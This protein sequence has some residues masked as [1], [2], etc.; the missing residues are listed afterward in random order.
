MLPV[1][2][3]VT[4][5]TFLM[6]HLIP[7]DPA[8]IMAGEKARPDAVEAMRV[9]LGLDKP[10][11]ERYW[12]YLK[13]LVTLD[14]GTSMKFSRPV[15]EMIGERLPV[16]VVLTLFSTALGLLFALPL[17]YISGTHK[18]QPS[19]H[20]IRISTLVAIAMPSFWIGLLLMIP[21]GKAALVACGRLGRDEHFHEA[22]MP[23]SAG[24]YAVA[25]DGCNPDQGHAKFRGGYCSPGLRGF[26]QVQGPFRRRCAASPYYSKFNGVNRNPAVHAHGRAAGRQCDYRNGI[27]PA[28]R[29]ADL[30]CDFRERLILWYSR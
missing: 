26:R 30:R 18:D 6:I 29:Q 25:D 5:I 14:L 22:E 8:R 23:H 10:L 1:L 2:L 19:D 16:T 7:G 15:A 17:G 4:I 28:D 9:K 24:V 11:W 12:I 20:A 3:V 13:N 27:C 21:F